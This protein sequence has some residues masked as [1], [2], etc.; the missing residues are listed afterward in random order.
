M[1]YF[2]K[3]N[4]YRLVRYVHHFRRQQRHQQL[5]LLLGDKQISEN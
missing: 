5:Q 4:I 3:V 2:L 1:N